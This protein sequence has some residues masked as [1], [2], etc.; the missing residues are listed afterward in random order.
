M[1]NYT[2]VTAPAIRH[3][4]NMPLPEVFRYLR[5]MRSEFS[6]KYFQHQMNICQYLSDPLPIV[7]F[8]VPSLTPWNQDST[9]AGTLVNKCKALREECTGVHN[10]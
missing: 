8:V 2:V 1:T 4:G 3:P 7:Y 5:P 10:K 9:K 6:D